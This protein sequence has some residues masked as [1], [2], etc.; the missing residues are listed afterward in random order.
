MPSRSVLSVLLTLCAL[1]IL[2]VTGWWKLFFLGAVLG[3]A[4][5]GLWLLFSRS[6]SR[7]VRVRMSRR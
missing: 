1:V 5:M 4:A 2:I 3:T 6:F 7:G